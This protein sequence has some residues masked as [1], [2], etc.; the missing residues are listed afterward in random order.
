MNDKDQF[1]N[2]L[3]EALSEYREVEPLAGIEDRVLERLRLQ[4]APRRV[5]WWKWAAVA[6]CAA[7][8]LVAIWIG[9]GSIRL[10][11]APPNQAATRQQ[12]V[13]NPGTTPAGEKSNGY[14]K[15]APQV[16]ASENVRTHGEGTQAAQGLPSEYVAHVE[17]ASSN[18]PKAGEFPSPTPLTAEEH[19][20]LALAKENPDALLNQ[21]DR[22]RDLEI[23]PIE[24]KPLADIDAPAQ[25]NS[26]E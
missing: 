11:D 19:V 10:H 21:P 9:A 4:P 6:A 16:I 24:I 1:D 12:E 25:E 13:A 26:N 3:H 5:S 22:S 14:Q 2:I 18:G 17:T 23:A 20:L 8:V 7:M 15:H